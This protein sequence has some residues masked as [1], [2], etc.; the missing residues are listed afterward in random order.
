MDNYIDKINKDNVDYELKDSNAARS[1]DGDASHVQEANEIYTT[2]SQSQTDAFAYRTAAGAMSINSGLATISTIYGNTI[3]TGHTD[4][5]LTATGNFQTDGTT[6]ALDK[7]TWR[8]QSLENGAYTFVYDGAWK[9]NDTTVTLS[10]YGLTV[11]G[12]VVADDSIT[13]EYVALVVGNLATATP[14]AFKATGFNQY[15]A[16]AGYA[17]VVGGNQYRVAGTY[18]AVQFSTTPTGTKTPVTVENNKFTPEEDGYIF[19]TGSGN[20]LVALVWSGTMDSE[21][22]SAYSDNGFNIPTTDADGTQLPTA[23]YGLPSVYGVRDEID[24]AGKLYQQ[25]IGHYAYSAQ[26]LATVEALGV[27][28]IYDLSD[29]FYV[30]PDLVVYE[31]ASTVSGAYQVNDYGT[32]EW[33]G[34]NV[35]I[36]TVI[37]YGNSLVD[38]LRNL[39]DIQSIGTGLTLDANGELSFEG[40]GG[41]SSELAHK[42]TT[43]DYNYPASS[44]NSIALWLLEPGVYW[45]DT[46]DSVS[47]KWIASGTEF[48]LNTHLYTTYIVGGKYATNR[49]IV[50]LSSGSS[51]SSQAGW[52]YNAKLS[53]G[54][55]VNSQRILWDAST[56]DSLTSTNTWRPLSA[57][58]GKVLNEK[59]QTLETRLAALEGNA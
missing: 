58:Q 52:V 41:G 31:L 51:S 34:T 27:D 28:Y 20:I 26:N 32:E 39:A 1:V 10:T 50:A 25:R 40:G 23:T 47:I 21:P 7:A 36:T 12:T 37:T 16:T 6:V 38:K 5:I 49:T 15:N 14:T 19:V 13:V 24:F 55:A 4:E 53:N 11:T 56:Q 59:I 46:N 22:W 33:T 29:I 43:A 2:T 18:T 42:L 54:S 48:E 45:R 30:L 9:L 8:T 57:N 44:P 3:Q 35:P 17:K